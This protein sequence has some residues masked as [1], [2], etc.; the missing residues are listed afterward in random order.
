MSALHAVAEAGSFTHAGHDLGLSQSA[1]SRQISALEADLAVALFH[2]HARG[3][4]LTEQGEMVAAKAGLE[5]LVADFGEHAI[6]RV[7]PVDS[8][9]WWLL[10]LRAYTRVSGDD[11]LA[12]RQEFQR[13]IRLIVE[14][15]LEAGHEMLPTILVP[16]DYLG[17][18]L[19]L[20]QDR[21]GVQLDLTYAGSRAMV[22][23]D[24]PLNEVVFDF[25][26]RLKSVSQGYAS[27]SYE[28]LDYQVAD[29][30]KVDLLV[31]KERV[32]ALSIIVHRDKAQ[33]RGRELV[34]RM[35]ELIPRQ[36]F[37]VAI[38]AAVG[39]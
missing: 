26:D 38:Q 4:I 34:E 21:R 33:Y 22:V 1:V 16:D 39:S 28:P 23:Y 24:L 35:R 3:L 31:N 20:C 29:L 13:S 25:Y 2:R 17:D 6:A 8:G 27:F 9:F 18:V 12:R 36:M 14:I 7:T 5:Q 10:L 11:S 19:K 37:D 32:D 30:V 15:G